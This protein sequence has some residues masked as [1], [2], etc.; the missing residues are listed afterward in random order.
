MGM[1]YVQPM[2]SMEET[3]WEPWGEAQGV[4]DVPDGVL[5]RLELPR[6]AMK[7]L[8]PL[9]ALGRYDLQSI[10]LAGRPD[11]WSVLS[12]LDRLSFW[13]LKFRPKLGYGGSGNNALG[14]SEPQPDGVLQ[15]AEDRSMGHVYVSA[16]SQWGSPENWQPWQDAKGAV[17]VPREG[18]VVRLELSNEAM[19]DLSPLAALGQHD[20]QSISFRHKPRSWAELA[21]LDG[22]MFWELEYH[23][24]LGYGGSVPVD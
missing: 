7:D 13:E 2:G 5:V 1:L 21:Y 20:L 3:A 11:S 18:Y 24:S 23:A 17:T 10:L 19:S 4:L 14:D 15:F 6:Q 22:L 9:D 16:L 8:T 12:H